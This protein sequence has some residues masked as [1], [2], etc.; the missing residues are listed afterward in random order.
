PV[1]TKLAILLEEGESAAAITE[2]AAATAPTPK[3]EAPQAQPTPLP[4]QQAPEAPAAAPA[5]PAVASRD[6]GERIK[7]SPLARRIAQQKGIDLAAVKGTGPN[8][9]IIKADVE[10]FQ[11]AAAQA[12]A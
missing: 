9:R 2:D 7:A 10:A 4:Q 1:G 6:G 11:P 12:A 3:A 5:A 8:G